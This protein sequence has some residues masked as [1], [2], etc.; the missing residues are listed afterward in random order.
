VR[1]ASDAVRSGAELTGRLLAFAR[2]QPLEPKPVDLRGQ[3]EETAAL[4]RRTIGATIEVRTAVPDGLPP[5]LVDP[6][7]LQNAMLNLALNARDAMPDGGALVIEVAAIDPDQAAIAATD[8]RPG[9]YLLLSVTD[10]GIGMSAEVRDRAFEPFYTTKAAGTGTG[11]GLAMVYGFAK[12]SGG[13]A[14][15]HSEPGH[16]TTVRLYLPQAEPTQAA[17]TPAREVL[18]AAFPG[19][20]ETVLVVEDEPLIRRNAV[21]RLAGFGYRVREA[22]DG[23]TAL[24][25]LEEDRSVDLLF[26]DMVMP[27]GLTGRELAKLA[28]RRRPGLPVVF[29]SGS[30]MVDGARWLRKPY[31]ALDLARTLR[32]ALDEAVNGPVSLNRHGAHL[33][34]GVART[35]ASRSG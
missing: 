8:L 29:T 18:P 31:T 2:R 3:I 13:H 6:G 28:W 22:S 9:G 23:P 7:Q 11:L 33:G 24:K 14:R 27:G 34:L 12:Q 21:T 1:E 25:L 5:A 26:T 20:G 4:L 35:G 10:T 15:I 17:A 19:R 16:G 30:G 32:Q